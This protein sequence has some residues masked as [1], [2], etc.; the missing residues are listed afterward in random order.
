MRR[1][2]LIELH[3]KPWYPDSWRDL[4]QRGM[5]ASHPFTDPF[6]NFYLPFGRF[7]QRLRPKS[8]LDLCSGSGD[9][10]CMMWN[11]IV[12]DLDREHRPVLI[13]SDLFPNVE[14]FEKLKKEHAGLVDYYSEK[15]N[16]LRPPANAPRVRTLLN[17]LHHFRPNEVR[18]ILQDV[19]DNADG[20]A[21]FEGTG[22][23]WKN[24]IT[25]LLLVPFLAAFMIA[26]LLRPFRFRN[27]LWGILIPVIPMTAVFDG[28]VSSFRTYTVEELKE[29]TAALGN[30]SFE[31]EIGTAYMSKTGLDATYLLGWRKDRL[32]AESL[33]DR[34]GNTL[35]QQ[36]EEG[37]PA[38]S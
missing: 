20:I 11:D 26:F 29:F 34:P 17:S 28:L 9:A 22:R 12:P 18:T 19:V 21:V 16:A 7:L 30:G 5:G 27:L 8:I 6:E 15:V 31:W 2:H 23:T 36:M 24:V 3:E 10:A 33:A 1:L 38:S 13:L 25:V 4:F 37:P 32:A 35:Q 14:A